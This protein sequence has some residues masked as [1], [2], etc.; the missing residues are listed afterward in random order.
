MTDALLTHSLLDDWI[1][2][3]IEALNAIPGVATLQSCAGHEQGERRPASSE[4]HACAGHLWFMPT[5]LFSS[6]R[7]TALALT[8]G[9][10]AVSVQ[11]GREVHPIIELTFRRTAREALLPSLTALLAKWAEIDSELA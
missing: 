2:P 11:Y 5:P 6:W 10:E 9:V 1:R 8:D 4:T 3:H 7:L